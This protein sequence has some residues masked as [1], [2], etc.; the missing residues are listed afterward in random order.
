MHGYPSI[1]AKL[2]GSPAF[3]DNMF[4]VF[5]PSTSSKVGNSSTIADIAV[6]WEHEL[7]VDTGGREF[8]AQ[9]GRGV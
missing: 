4:V 5:V 8:I 9:H 6:V 1:A 3:L 2:D 7:I